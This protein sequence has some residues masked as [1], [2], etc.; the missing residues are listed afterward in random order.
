MAAQAS[1][2]RATPVYLTYNTLR[3]V[4]SPEDTQAGRKRYCGVA[5]ADSFF[6]LDTEENVRAYLGRDEENNKRKSTKV[7]MAIR[8]TLA[9]NRECFPLLNSASSSLLAKQKLTTTR[10][11]L[12]SHF[13]P[14]ASS[15]AHK[16][17]VY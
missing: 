8:E 9:E 10:S 1:S 5:S 11:H 16:L 14:P 12:K 6:A 2:G 17:R 3:S 7:N 13:I 15:T 4:N